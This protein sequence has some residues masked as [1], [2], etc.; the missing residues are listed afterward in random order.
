MQEKIHLS[1]AH[2]GGTEQKYIQEAFDT[3]WITTLGPNVS[4]FEGQLSSFLGAEH[5]VALSSGTAAIHIALLLLGVKPGDEVICQSMT[6]AASANPIVYLGA[7]PVFVD[8]DSRTWNM[9]PEHLERAIQDRIE[10]VGV[11]PKAI[12]PV[13]LYGMPASM[14]E[15]TSIAQRYEIPIIEDAAEALGSSLNGVFCGTWGDYACLSFNGN[16][17]ITTSGGGALVCST[18][19]QAQ[20]ALFLATQARD[21]APHYQHSVI[22]YNYRM[23]NVCAGIGRGQMEVLEKRIARRR[24]INQLYRNGLAS[25]KN[26]SFQSEP[27]EYYHSNFWLTAIQIH[28]PQEEV[29]LR[30]ELRI[31]LESKQVE[32]RPIWKPLH[33]QP[34]FRLAPYYGEG[35]C[36]SIFRQGLC[37]PSSSSLKDEQ[38]SYVCDLIND[39]LN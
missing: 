12:I 30:E 31:F 17:I 20:R 24:E 18:K 27:S 9:S 26:I 23:S 14:D 13:H 10:R 25:L 3:H 37:L 16:K 4:A 33:Q 22:G 6:F 1:I 34:V 29:L 19:E 32:S 35:V 7:K 8:S 5:I 39:C 28:S 2:M 38:I 15:I 36:D 21:D 11:K